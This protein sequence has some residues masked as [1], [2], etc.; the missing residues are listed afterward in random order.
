MKKLQRMLL[1]LCFRK[2][3]GPGDFNCQA[4]RSEV[5]IIEN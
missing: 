5:F 1:V 3:C 2:I 4:E